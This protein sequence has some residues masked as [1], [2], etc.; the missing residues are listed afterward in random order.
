ML[1]G[2]ELQEALKG[3]VRRPDPAA[4][5]LGV[6]EAMGECHR[7]R[8]CEG[9]RNIV[10]GVGDPAARLLVLGEGP[11]EQEDRKGEP[12]VGPAGEM[13][14]GMLEKVLGLQRREVYILNMV[15]C[16]PPNNRNP[17]DDELEACRPF[18]RA[19][20]ASVRPDLVLLLGSVAS[21]ALLGQGI[22][23]ARGQWHTM[24]WPGGGARVMATFH[25]AYLLRK[26]E[27]KRLTL[28]DLRALKAEL[29]KLPPRG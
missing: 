3:A 20:L 15:K 9:R 8:L 12:F 24:A 25:P 18:L 22:T 17:Q 29:D 2:T 27:D 23:V 16:R 28:Q 19:Q 14:D 7:C 13:L 4:R 6:R 11:G 5:L 21:K 1:T 26:P 10:F